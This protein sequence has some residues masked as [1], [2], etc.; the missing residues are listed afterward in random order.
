MF[1]NGGWHFNY[2]SEPEEISKKLKTFAHTEYDKDKF[3][4]LDT[5]KENINSMKDLF[6]KGY[7]Y[8]KVKLDNTFP[9]YILNNQEKFNQ[10]II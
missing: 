1:E 7:Q 2:L 5:I 6:N 4:N 8:H 10:W 9:E 3:T